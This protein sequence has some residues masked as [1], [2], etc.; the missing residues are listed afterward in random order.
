MIEENTQ[1]YE[2]DTNNGILQDLEGQIVV[3]SRGKLLFSTHLISELEER[4][5]SEFQNIQKYTL[6]ISGTRRIMD[7][8]RLTQN[9][10]RRE[11]DFDEF[12]RGIPTL[13]HYEFMVT[14][15]LGYEE[16]K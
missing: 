11:D 16:T 14:I 15:G 5:E 13:S 3:Y 4:M 9:Q 6:A 7:M 8:Q 10:N 2:R 12:F 1:A